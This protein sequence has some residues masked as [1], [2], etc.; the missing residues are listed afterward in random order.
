MLGT[1]FLS[2]YIESAKSLSKECFFQTIE[3]NDA[4]KLYSTKSAIFID[5]RHRDFYK[6]ERI[7]GAYSF[8]YHERK[9]WEKQIIAEI[10][11]E[12]VIIVYCDSYFC[13]LATATANHLISLGYC[14]VY[15]LIG[16]IDL[17]KE[18][19]YPVTSS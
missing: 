8:P 3:I 17:W 5:G 14:N 11:I 7:P 6:E 1:I 16:G 19:S 18:H 15:G 2:Y 4:Y 12:S 13:G 9:R 10:N